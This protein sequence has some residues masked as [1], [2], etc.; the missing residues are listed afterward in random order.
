MLSLSTAPSS[1]K[2]VASSSRS[3]TNGSWSSASS[4]E[5]G[6]ALSSHLIYV[7]PVGHLENEYLYSLPV[8]TS[9]AGSTEVK[10]VKK[11]LEGLEGVKHVDIMIPKRR[12]KGRMD[13][14]PPSAEYCQ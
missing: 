10:D 8:P 4:V 7:G 13:C 5:S 1:N 2:P 11:W 6:P 14:P 9:K 3:S 12:H